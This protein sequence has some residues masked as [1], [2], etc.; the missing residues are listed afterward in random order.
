MPSLGETEA[1]RGWK[2]PP[3]FEPS[4][5]GRAKI[6]PPFCCPALGGRG[7]PGRAIP[8]PLTSASPDDEVTPPLHPTE[9]LHQDV[10]R[11]PA[12]Q[13]RP[14]PNSCPPSSCSCPPGARHPPPR[15]EIQSRPGRCLLPSPRE[16]GQ[17]L[18]IRLNPV[19][20]APLT[21]S[22]ATGRVGGGGSS[23]RVMGES[24]STYPASA[25]PHGGR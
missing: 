10:P 1:Q 23:V 11:H 15:A 14:W 24:A 12:A 13:E 9:T 6:W 2:P 5:V 18:L 20:D 19:D 21:R 7:V 22:Q 4:Q 25:R 16:S 3:G 17:T 8:A